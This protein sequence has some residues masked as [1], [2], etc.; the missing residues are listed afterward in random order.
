MPF[1]AKIW[2]NSHFLKVFQFSKT[3]FLYLFLAV[4]CLRCCTGFLQLQQA[5]ATLQ[6]RYTGFP[7]QW[8]LFLRSTGS[9]VSGLQELRH[10]GFIVAVP[11]LQSTSSIAVAQGLSCF[12]ACGIFLDQRSNSLSL[13]LAGGFFTTEPPGKPSFSFFLTHANH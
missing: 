4:M 13:A 12:G 9:R 7:Q 11:R 5:G 2:R 1:M 3:L 10:L 6:L 8:L